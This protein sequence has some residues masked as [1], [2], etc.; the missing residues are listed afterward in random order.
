LI[1]TGLFQCK[2]Q[3]FGNFHAAFH[4]FCKDIFSADLLYPECCHDF[5]L[6][7]KDPNIHEDFAAAEDISYHDQGIADPH[8]DNH[9][10]AFDIVLNASIK[11]GCHED[12]IFPLKTLKMMSRLT[13]QNVT[14]LDLQQILRTTMLPDLQTRKVVVTTRNKIFRNY[15]I[16]S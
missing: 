13:D 14:E 15:L 8:Y 4:L 5:N 16:F 7:N 9:G 3:F 12:Q 1:G 11:D 6:L 10:D 2:Y